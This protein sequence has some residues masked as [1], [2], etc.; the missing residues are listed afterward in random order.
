M[1]EPCSTCVHKE[2]D[3]GGCRCQAYML[4]QD[5]AAADPVCRLSPQHHLVQA[6]V[7]EAALSAATPHV[8]EHPLLFR[9]PVNSRRLTEPTR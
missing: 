2:E 5:A 1:K 4:A 9:D 7:A 3:L 8:T 6:A